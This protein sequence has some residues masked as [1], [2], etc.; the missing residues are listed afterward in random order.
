MT[1]I[2]Q[3][4]APDSAFEALRKYFSDKE[5]VDLTL[6]ASTINAWNRIAI[7][8]RAVPGRYRPATTAASAS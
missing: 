8:L 1:L 6:L 2:S 7:A 4:H 5:I 3:T